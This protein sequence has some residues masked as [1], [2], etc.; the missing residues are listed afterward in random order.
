MEF[1]LGVYKSLWVGVKHSV[2]CISREDTEKITRILK[3]MCKFWLEIP[4]KSALG[5]F[6]GDDDISDC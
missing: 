1:F 5:L 4:G 2:L 3:Y 6:F